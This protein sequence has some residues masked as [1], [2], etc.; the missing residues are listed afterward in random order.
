MNHDYSEII[1]LLHHYC[2]RIIIPWLA[3][4]TIISHNHHPSI[5]PLSLLKVILCLLLL[6]LLLL[7][8]FLLLYYY[9]YYYYYYC[10]I[11]IVDILVYYWDD[12]YS[13]INIPWIIPSWWNLMK[14][15]QSRLARSASPWALG[16][17]SCNC[18]ASGCVPGSRAET[19]KRDGK[20]MGKPW[21]S[22]SSYMDMEMGQNLLYIYIYIYIY[23]LWCPIFFQNCPSWGSDFCSKNGQ[24]YW[25]LQCFVTKVGLK[26]LF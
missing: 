17:R 24:K 5:I 12:Y 15:R 14:N 2:T 13:T 22:R 9:Y 10:I 4:I 18:W 3:V 7:F 23:T 11:I 21:E 20:M 16:W 25:Y 26:P 19:P 1:P 8:F 6:W